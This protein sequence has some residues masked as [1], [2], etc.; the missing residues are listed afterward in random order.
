MQQLGRRQQ[1]R[2]VRLEALHV[3]R[4]PPQQQQQQQWRL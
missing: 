1:G 4:L 3:E 2:C